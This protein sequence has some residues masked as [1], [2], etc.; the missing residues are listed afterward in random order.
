MNSSLTIVLFLPINYQPDGKPIKLLIKTSSAIQGRRVGGTL[1]LLLHLE[2]K[3]KKS[4]QKV[5]VL[6]FK[7]LK[8]LL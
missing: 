5:S 3:E 6:S 1:E 2:K 7:F 8:V 4:I